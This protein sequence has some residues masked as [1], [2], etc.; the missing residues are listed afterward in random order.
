[1]RTGEFVVSNEPKADLRRGALPPGHPS[2]N[3]YMGLPIY[4][5]NML[6]GMAGIA[7]QQA[8]YDEKLFYQLKQVLG[9]IGSLIAGYQNL[10][11]PHNKK[12]KKNSI[13]R[14]K[15]FEKKKELRLL[16]SLKNN[17]MMKQ[18]ILPCYAY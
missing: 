11:S 15:H 3:S 10:A 7:N 9:T 5:E 2:L 18:P 8:G 14:K 17:L 16:K 6:I 13:K 4:S 12:L 1:M